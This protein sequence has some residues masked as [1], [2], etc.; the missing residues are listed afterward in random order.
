MTAES[1]N[2]IR[3]TKYVGEHEAVKA[4]RTLFGNHIDMNT[5]FLAHLQPGE[6]KSA[7]RQKA[8][9]NHPDLFEVEPTH[10]RQAQNE[11][12]RKIH[13]AYEVMQIYFQQREERPRGFTADRT[14]PHRSAHGAEKAGD[15]RSRRPACASRADML[16]HQGRVP[17]QTLQIGRYLY[18]RGRISFGALTRAILWQ[19]NQRPVIGDLARRWGVLD[20]AG[21]AKIS[22]ACDRPRLFGERAVMLGLL[23]SFQV[24]TLLLFQRAQQ[25]R[26]GS[27]FVRNN[28]I[29]HGEMERLVIE[30]R[31][32]NAS[33]LAGAMGNAR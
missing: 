3:L 28:L 8:K 17:S 12:F 20:T 32:H 16:Y 11:D 4:C 7:Y 24:R 22:R 10:V 25:G 14:Q 1:N 5:E 13:Q 33:V 21:I 30:L 19:R 15:V 6:V 31:E 29:E 27:Y 18:Y 26:L 23:T 9:E 2:T